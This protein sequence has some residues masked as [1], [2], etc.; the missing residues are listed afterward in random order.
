[1]SYLSSI[2]SLKRMQKRYRNLIDKT[3]SDAFNES[4]V[5]EFYEEHLEDLESKIRV[6]MEE[7]EN[8]LKEIGYEE[9]LNNLQ[10]IP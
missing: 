5:I 8:K 2:D 3:K 6:Y 4:D 7:V 9:K 10:T 1:M